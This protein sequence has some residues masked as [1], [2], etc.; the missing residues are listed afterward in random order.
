[1]RNK[2]HRHA[3]I[4]LQLAQQQQDLDLHRGIERRGRLIGEKNPGLARQRQ[5]DHRALPHAAGHFVRIGI[6]P[7]FGRGNSH[8]FQHF[9]RA[10]QR[11]GM[12]LA[13]V[14]HHRFR[15]LRPDSIDGIERKRRFL[16]DHRNCLATKC[17]ELFII[18]RQHVAPENLN[19]PGNLR[20]FL[21]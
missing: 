5:R 18:K 10:S 7:A 14:P 20:P 6:E 2:N 19:A 9:Q 17:R 12:A 3:E 1:M 16:E 11:T 21:R 4:A 8:H 15:N 13:F